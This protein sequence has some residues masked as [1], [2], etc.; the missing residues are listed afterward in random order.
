[1]DE[2]GGGVIGVG[3][4]VCYRCLMLYSLSE[5]RWK[6]F[7]AGEEDRNIRCTTK[8]VDPDFQCNHEP[9]KSK[10]KHAREGEQPYVYFAFGAKQDN[11]KLD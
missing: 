1:M 4:G 7:R 11:N 2:V 8:V 9:Q 10:S 3:G 5:N 6:C